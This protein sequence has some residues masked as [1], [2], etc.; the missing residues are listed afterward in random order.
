MGVG[1]LAAGKIDDAGIRKVRQLGVDHVLS[2]GPRIPWEEDRLR[3][4]MDTLK[5]GGLTLGNMM[6]AGFPKTIYGKDGRDEEIEKVK[7]SL[8]V[9]GKVGLPVVEYDFYAHRAIEGY[10]AET[11]RG[12]AGLT[13]FDYDRMKDLPPL[14]QEALTPSMKCGRTSRIPEGRDSSRRAGRGPDGP[15]SQRSARALEPGLAADHGNRSRLEASD[16]DREEP[17]RTESPSIVA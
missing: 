10:Y 2:G 17:L 11:G 1:G 6:I 9:A 13:A 15:A 3:E 12:G 14:P 16:R 4:M 5:A 7:Q 8:R